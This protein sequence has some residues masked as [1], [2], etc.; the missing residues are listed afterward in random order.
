MTSPMARCPSGMKHSVR[1]GA[2]VP[3]NQ[4]HVPQPPMAN[5]V[6]LASNAADHVEIP[7][8]LILLQL[9]W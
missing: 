8:A 3:V 7:A 9:G 4:I 1:L 2:A 6:T 5:A